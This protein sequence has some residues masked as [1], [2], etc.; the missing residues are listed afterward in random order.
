MVA[1]VRGF[2]VASVAAVGLELPILAGKGIC[3]KL[4]QVVLS[5]F[6]T[7]CNPRNLPDAI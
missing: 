1:D 5:R 6:V 2:Q 7:A 3:R 4:A